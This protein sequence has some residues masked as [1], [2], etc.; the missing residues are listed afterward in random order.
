MCG[1]STV[2]FLDA[3]DSVEEVAVGEFHELYTATLG[4]VAPD[5]SWM[6]RLAQDLLL[7]CLLR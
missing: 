2:A 5:E 3:A 6:V 1:R 4:L 7:H